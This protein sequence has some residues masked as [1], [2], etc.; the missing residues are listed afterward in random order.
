MG[1][2]KSVLVIAN[3]TAASDELCEK[4]SERG[5][6]EPVK[7]TLVVPAT[8]AGGGAGVAQQTVARAVE[9]LRDAG[10]DVDGVVGN[11]DPA[12]AVT[13]TWDPRR[14]DE[15][16]VSTLPIGSSRWLS[17]GLPQRIARLTGALVTTVVCSPPKTPSVISA[18]PR[19]EERGLGPLAVLG[20]GG[21][22][23][24]ARATP[25]GD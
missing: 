14:F 8:S 22:R 16:V 4:L 12:V 20:W 23:G 13:E 7:F 19:H 5:R 2:Q 3:V 17:A 25:E 6:R 9:R 11:P 10:L 15:I 1:L 24:R 21:P 18:P